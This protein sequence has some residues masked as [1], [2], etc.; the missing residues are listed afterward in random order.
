MED[1]EGTVAGPLVLSVEGFH[2]DI[3]ST[4][5]VFGEPNLGP[6]PVAER[7]EAAAEIA[8]RAGGDLGSNSGLVSGQVLLWRAVLVCDVTAA[9]IKAGVLVNHRGF[10]GAVPAELAREVLLAAPRAFARRVG[11]CSPEC[12]AQVPM[13]DRA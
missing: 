1:L 7:R 11:R 9:E 8:L 5:L 12:A 10:G 13:A 6:T 2:S 3:P 4:E